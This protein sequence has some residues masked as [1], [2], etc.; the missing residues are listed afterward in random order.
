MRIIDRAHKFFYSLAADDP[1]WF[2][3]GADAGR[4]LDAEQK[5]GQTA[6]MIQMQV[7]DPD[8]IEVWPIQVFLRHPVWGVGAAIEQERPSVGLQ[9]EAG[10]GATPMKDRSAGTENHELHVQ[11][12]NLKTQNCKAKTVHLTGAQGSPVANL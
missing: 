11:R 6:A 1:Q 8:G 4:P 2:C 9:P 10:R 5:R 12:L 3:A 7:T